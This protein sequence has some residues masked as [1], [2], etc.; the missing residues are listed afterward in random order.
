MDSLEPCNPPN[1][2][3]LLMLEE[4]ASGEDSTVWE[5]DYDGSAPP[6]GLGGTPQKLHTWLTS[7]AMSGGR[8]KL[9]GAESQRRELEQAR[10]ALQRSESKLTG[11]IQAVMDAILSVNEQQHIVMF[12]PSAKKMFGIMGSAMG[13]NLDKLIPPRFRGAYAEQR[14]MGGHVN[15]FGR[16]A[17]GTWNTPAAESGCR[18][19]KKTVEQYGRKIWMESEVGG[20]ATFKFILRASKPAT[21]PTEGSQHAHAVA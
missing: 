15:L 13:R 18:F 5:M 19:A 11:I 17:D 21:N 20:G 12:N 14:M 9:G 16:R 1:K 4:G 7:Q 10:E 3:R 8:K 2:L 6:R